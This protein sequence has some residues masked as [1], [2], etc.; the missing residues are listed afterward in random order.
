MKGP[1]DL[2]RL[3][4][5]T[6]RYAE[7]G[8]RKAGLIGVYGGLLLALPAGLGTG[9][10]LG[11]VLVQRTGSGP[12]PSFWQPFLYATGKL[13]L[14]LMLLTWS[15]PLLFLL[16][17]AP[18]RRTLYQPFGPVKAIEPAPKRPAPNGKLLWGC[19]AALMGTLLLGFALGW[20]QGE[21]AFFLRV[22]GAIL[23]GGVFVAMVRSRQPRED[24]LALALLLWGNAALAA[25]SP[26]GLWALTSWLFSALGLVTM[27][28]GVWQHQAYLRLRRELEQL[29][30]P[31]QP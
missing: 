26:A 19:F 12:W 28:C 6:R 2:D 27:A 9:L 18:L 25:A 20:F 24:E 11:R 1:Q 23:L 3:S 22:T 29:A 10:A 17:S 21:E 13:P 31:G 5:L 15:T 7:Y 14:W 8:G 4:N 30:P 16:G